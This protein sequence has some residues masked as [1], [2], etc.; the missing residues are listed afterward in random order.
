MERLL[1]KLGYHHVKGE[2]RHNMAEFEG[3][4]AF[5]NDYLLRK[6]ANRD[7]RNNPIVAEVFLDES[8]CNANHV[9]GRTWL[10]SEKIRYDKTGR[11][12][13]CVNLSRYYFK[14]C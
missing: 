5:R 2:R 7:N 13:R 10:T 3:N 14:I 8:Y 11:G 12:G 1:K 4:I 9:T 6:L